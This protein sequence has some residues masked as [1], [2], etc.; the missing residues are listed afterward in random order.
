ML[1]TDKSGRELIKKH[2]PF[3]LKTYDG[4][5]V[6]IVF[7]RTCL[8]SRFYVLFSSTSNGLMR[9]VISFCT[10]MVC[11]AFPKVLT[12]CNLISFT[13]TGGVYADL[14]YEPLVNFWHY[15]PQDRVAFVESPFKY[16][17]LVQNS[18]M[19]SPRGDPFWISV[20]KTLEAQRLKPVFH[21]TGTRCT[22]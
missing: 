12:L 16:V 19:S 21:S 13:R 9:C 20:F 1:W 5:Q 11:E 3:F 17:E 18:F 8:E 7:L 4:Y 22:S 6:Q 14:D 10:I 2:Y 15:I